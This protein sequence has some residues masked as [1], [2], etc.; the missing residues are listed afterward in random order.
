MRE[1]TGKAGETRIMVSVQIDEEAWEEA[2]RTAS[3]AEYLLGWALVIAGESFMD[4]KT[5]GPV[6]TG[7]DGGKESP[8]VG[9]W[10][11]Y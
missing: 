1:G 4:G 11:A 10:R 7:S 6:F 5:S 8:H 3:G 2:N 9:T